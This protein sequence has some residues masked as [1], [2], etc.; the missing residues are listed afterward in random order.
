MPL[1]DY[2]WTRNAARGGAPPA[3]DDDRI[4]P[5]APYDPRTRRFHNPPGRP[6]KPNDEK[7]WRAFVKLRMCDRERPVVPAD[8]SAG[9]RPPPPASLGRPRAS[10]LPVLSPSNEGS[11][12]FRSP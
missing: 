5:G 7:A 6:K 9:A 1:R 12:P 4:G 3:V 11:R 10:P 2:L 8:H